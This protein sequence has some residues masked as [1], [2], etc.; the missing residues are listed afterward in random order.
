MFLVSNFC[1]LFSLTLS[2]IRKFHC[3]DERQAEE[4][5]RTPLLIRMKTPLLNLNFFEDPD[6]V[7]VWHLHNQ[8]LATRLFLFL[9]A[10]TL[11]FLILFTSLSYTT[12][13]VI[14]KQP[15]TDVYLQLEAQPYS[16]T[17]V[18][19]CT[20]IS[21][22]YK[23]FISFQP[24]Y[25]QICSSIFLSEDWL[26]YITSNSAVS[27]KDFRF[28]SGLFFPNLMSF[29]NVSSETI[30][31]ELLSFNSTKYVTK[32][33][34]P[35]DL[36]KS[37]TQQIINS[38]E[39]I[40]RNT[41]LLQIATFQQTITGNALFS[42][43]QTNFFYQ[44]TNITNSLNLLFFPYYY[45]PDENNKNITCSCKLSAANCDQLTGI[46]DFTSGTVR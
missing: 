15:S 7:T 31:N 23:S 45:R 1:I 2:G 4:E 5:K 42:A 32:N 41:F 22:E 38:F 46:Y 13:T 35:R 40:S 14:V 6:E 20:S 19:P 17:L 3:L 10:I 24:I 25:H 28:V 12:E 34:Q 18:C 43:A 21:N 39:Q 8:R 36:F 37:A 29:C 26:Y 16:R 44:P 27:S 11:L 30:S 33:V 9:M